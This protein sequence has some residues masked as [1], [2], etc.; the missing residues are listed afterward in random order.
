MK[1]I[2][3]ILAL[4]LVVILMAGCTMKSEAGL[5]ITEDGKINSTVTVA[6]D[7][8]MIDGLLSM[9]EMGNMEEEQQ[10]QKTYTEEE[11]WA[12]VEQDKPEGAIRY[13]KDGLKGITSTQE[14]GTL[15]NVSATSAPARVNIVESQDDESDETEGTEF[16]LKDKILFIKDG[17]KYKSNMTIDLGE[18]VQQMESY[19]SMGAIFEV[20]FTITL[21][22]KPTSNNATKVSED[23][24]TLT[25]DLL[26]TKDIE[27]E[28]ELSGAEKEATKEDKKE[29]SSS[30][31][32]PLIFVGIG[33]A[34]LVVVVIVVVV[35]TSSKKKNANNQAVVA[36]A[37]PVQPMQ[38]P[39]TPVQ[40]VAPVTPV[41]P[42]EQVPVEPVQPIQPVPPV[43]PTEPVQPVQPVQPV[44]PV[45]P[46]EPVAPQDPNNNNQQM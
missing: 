5:V 15:D 45:Q 26:T 9:N 31:T 20:N 7:N 35:I 27:L 30:D 25:W 43:Q 19:K 29:S 32:N 41:E 37:T 17:N 34:V 2:R 40:P 36:P 21:P 18:E 16:A 28:F 8:E 10:E 4:V 39:V 42:V 22:V 44:A 46:T 14:L 3:K 33:A 23:G 24:K 6:Y 11:R 38:Q 12:F 13:E 1:K